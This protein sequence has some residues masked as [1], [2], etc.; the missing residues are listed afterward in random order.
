MVLADLKTGEEA[1]II[2][3]KGYGAFRKRL[4]EMG[5]VRGKVVKMV[6]IAP[7]NGPIEYSIMGYEVSLRQRE[8]AFVEVATAA[9]AAGMAGATGEL[10]EVATERARPDEDWNGRD[11]RVNVVIVG[12]PNAGKTTLFNRLSGAAK[13]VGNYGGVTVEAAE[14]TVG[15]GDYH[16]KLVDLPGTY[17]LSA[18]SEDERVVRDYIAEHAPDVIVNVVDA[19]NLERN[20][21]LTTQLI[22]MDVKVVVALNMYD[23]LEA[24]GATFDHEALGKMI[25]MPFVPTVAV[26]R[27]GMVELL[28]EVVEVY[29]G[30]SRCSRH[31]HVHYG[32][33]VEEGIA[34]TRKVLEE[35][36]DLVAGV[37]PRL[38]ALRLL[39]GDAETVEMVE[40]EGLT[41]I[42]AVRREQ[43]ARIEAALGEPV[44]AV[45]TDARYGFIAGALKETYREPREDRHQKTKRLDEVLTRG[46]QAYAYFILAMAATFSMTFFFGGALKGWM[47]DG[48]KLLIKL[49]KGNMDKGPLAD[50]V[51]DGIIAGVGGVIVFLPHIMLLF[52][53]L[54]FMEDTGYMARVA[55][56]MDKLMHKIG[57]HGKS[58]FP[59]FMG[60]GCNVPAIMA[61]RMLENKRDR[62]LTI[63]INPF[64]TCTARLPVYVVFVGAFFPG[65]RSGLVFSFLYLL[66][67]AV[68]ILMGWIFNKLLLKKEEAPFV[69]ELPPYRMPTPRT[70]WKHTCDKA[71][72]Y[73]KKMGIII[74]GASVIIWWLLNFPGSDKVT[75]RYA[76][77]WGV[78]AQQVHD[79]ANRKVVKVWLDKKE[80][81]ELQ[82]SSYMARISRAMNPVWEPLGFDWQAGAGILTGVAAKEV[83]VSTMSIIYLGYDEKKEDD[84]TTKLEGHLKI[85]YSELMAFI[86]MIF[87]LLYTPCSAAIAAIRKEVGWLWALFVMGYTT[88]LAW[89]VCY[90]LN[91]LLQWIH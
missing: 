25:G 80:K 1:V 7:R 35:E 4:N 37:S 71:K 38:L 27:Q 63:L 82:D 44:E 51:A 85:R 73:L 30:R 15:F 77:R 41:R 29:E 23:E 83:V 69:M 84:S 24:S 6:R 20:L 49:V 2:K 89:V 57:L 91:T 33:E 55:F 16:F 68:A 60:F 34:A 58:V 32:N 76:Q 65:F 53:F 64:M 48:V 43:A 87:V 86:F 54:S 40:R 79:T 81:A 42:D 14:A 12:N 50:V 46:W 59:M 74:M 52:L 72:Q 62:L 78:V 13:R 47:E 3:V 75:E 31:V 36:K 88:T 22:D 18:Y 39:E 70:M 9:E 56:I 67:I 26:K 66:G 11:K 17:S 61:T 21:Y 5:F 10:R 19:S 90:L 8:A 45:V 28:R